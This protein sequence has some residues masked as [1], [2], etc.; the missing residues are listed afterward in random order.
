MKYETPIAVPPVCSH[1]EF[2]REMGVMLQERYEKEYV[3]KIIEEDYAFLPPDARREVLKIAIE[4]IDDGEMMRVIYKNRR[5]A[6]IE[7]EVLEYLKT[8]DTILPEGFFNFRL[9]RYHEELRGLCARA[10]DEFRAKREY[11]EFLELLRFFVSVQISREEIVHV[12]WSNGE[13]RIQNRFRRDV[14][15]RYEAE[16]IDLASS[17]GATNEDLL[18]SALIA[19]APKK[20]VLHNP[21]P[22]EEPIV[23]TI[24]AVFDGKVEAEA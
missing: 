7:R 9:S 19:I 24:C 14:T 6:I 22:P 23:K 8:N 20:I 13:I 2:A 12:V 15:H 11:E 1:E 3:N 21:P 4:E 17:E 10:A 16:F 18:L 5:R